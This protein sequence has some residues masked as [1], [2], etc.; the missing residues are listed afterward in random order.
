MSTN[1]SVHAEV[2][3]VSALFRA[4]LA[5][6][7]AE[8][9][10]PDDTGEDYYPDRLPLPSPVIRYSCGCLYQLGHWRKLCVGAQLSNPN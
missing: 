8:V 2:K 7:Q 4:I 5:H 3:R 10:C 6:E 9:E 1:A